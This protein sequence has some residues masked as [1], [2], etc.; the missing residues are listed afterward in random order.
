MKIDVRYQMLEARNSV[1]GQVSPLGRNL[2][3]VCLVRN[4][5]TVKL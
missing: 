1:V 2:T 3:K 5:F 4:F